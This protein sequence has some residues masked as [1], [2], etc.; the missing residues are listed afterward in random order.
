MTW[1]ILAPLVAGISALRELVPGYRRWRRGEADL[2][3]ILERIGYAGLITG[4]GFGA[5]RHAF[6]AG[7]FIALLAPAEV[8]GLRL[9]PWLRRRRR[10]PPEPEQPRLPR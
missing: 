5:M 4:I 9:G 7:A 10:L 1:M 8:G 2:T 3:E 6:T